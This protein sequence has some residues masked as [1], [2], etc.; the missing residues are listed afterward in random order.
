M[1]KNKKIHKIFLENFRPFRAGRD[2]SFI[3]ICR[4]CSKGKITKKGRRKL[5][6]ENAKKPAKCEPYSQNDV[7]LTKSVDIFWGVW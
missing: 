1:G 6:V 2:F 4:G 5:V 7:F 3:A